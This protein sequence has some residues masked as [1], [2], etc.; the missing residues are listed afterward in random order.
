MAEPKAKSSPATKAAKQEKAKTT[1]R[2]PAR[3]V[4]VNGVA[5]MTHGAEEDDSKEMK[6][7]KGQKAG[8]TNRGASDTQ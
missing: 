1:E 8:E 2:P 3:Q 7:A 5:V 4:I 6:R